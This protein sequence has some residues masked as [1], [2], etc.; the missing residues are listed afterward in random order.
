MS[1][2]ITKQDVQVQADALL[3]NLD[4]DNHEAIVSQGSS[5]YGNSTRITVKD[6]ET[7]NFFPISHWIGSIHLGFTKR[8]TRDIL[9][10]INNGMWIAKRNKN[11]KQ[12]KLLPKKQ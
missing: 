4:L 7:G 8:E 3:R 6:H 1:D 5:L 2:R 12:D 9:Y 10:L 11:L